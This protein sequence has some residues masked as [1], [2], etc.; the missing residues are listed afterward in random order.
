[1]K[2]KGILI[3]DIDGDAYLRQYT[4]DGEFRDIEIA[5]DEISIEIDDPSIQLYKKVDGT[6]YL[7]YNE[8]ILGVT[9]RGR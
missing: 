6:E 3:F 4:K 8:S 9:E 2:L 1:M 7:D 5:L